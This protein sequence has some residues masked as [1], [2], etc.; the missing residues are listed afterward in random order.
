MKRPKPDL[1]MSLD[2]N[3]IEETSDIFL[4]S[5]KSRFPGVHW[6]RK[7]KK[8][9]ARLKLQGH[10]LHIGSFENEDQAH[11]ALKEASNCYGKSIT[12]SMVDSLGL[13]RHDR[14]S[15]ICSIND[16]GQNTVREAVETDEIELLQASG[17]L[18]GPGP[19]A[20]P[21]KDS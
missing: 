20:G 15:G 14:S 21:S 7:L 16:R 6:N 11:E 18:L 2:H 17:S 10:D 19:L 4:E 13:L 5:P 12:S 9:R 3:I 8:W 1:G